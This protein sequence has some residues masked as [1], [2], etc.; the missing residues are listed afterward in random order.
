MNIRTAKVPR[1]IAEYSLRLSLLLTASGSGILCVMVR[2]RLNSLTL[3]VFMP[4]W[5]ERN[6]K[7]TSDVTAH[8]GESLVLWGRSG[9][10]YNY[11][12]SFLLFTYMFPRSNQLLQLPRS[13][14][15]KHFLGMKTILFIC[16]IIWTTFHDWENRECSVQRSSSYSPEN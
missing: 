8:Q 1:L 4:I 11:S 7:R 3:S 9:R 15:I 14:L 6:E 5:K 16:R 13:L 10:K 2:A 12:F